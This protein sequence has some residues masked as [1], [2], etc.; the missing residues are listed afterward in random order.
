MEIFIENFAENVIASDLVNKI[1]ICQLSI[2][3]Y[4]G[5]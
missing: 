4:V 1:I 5:H 3:R 2:T